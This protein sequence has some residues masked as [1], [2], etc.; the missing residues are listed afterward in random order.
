MHKNILLIL[1]GIAA[2]A[3]AQ[4]FGDLEQRADEVA[5]VNLNSATLQAL[6]RACADN[7]AD[8]REAL[9]VLAGVTEINVRSL[10]FHSGN[11]PSDEEIVKLRGRLIPAGW[12]KFLT[13]HS[14]DPAETVE[15]YW[16]PEGFA[17][18]TWEEGE[19]TFVRIKGFLSPKDVP[20]LGNKFGIPGMREGLVIQP[21]PGLSKEPP[22]SPSSELRPAKLNFS[23]MVHEVEARE[24][25][26]HMRIPLFGLV[27][28]VAFVASGGSVRA[29][30]MAIFEDAPPTFVD[31]VAQ[32]VPAG[33]TPFVEVREE[34]ESTR[35]WLGE[36]GHGLRMLMANNDG[37]EGVLMTTK[38]NIQELEKSPLAWAGHH[39]SDGQ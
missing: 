13:S 38:V 26:H 30:D 14:K 34:G 19:I 32:S 15:G 4:D 18:L 24:G 36:V 3:A 2:L 9:R 35:I 39:S 28:P 20:V 8:V 11:M 5:I 31:A 1:L 23:A 12:P 16:G 7:D 21:P 10:E 22:A 27:K 33:W 6:L 29:L 25:I 37:S 17:I